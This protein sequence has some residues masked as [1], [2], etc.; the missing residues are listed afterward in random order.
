MFW[1]KRKQA[2]FSAEIEAHLQLEIERLR[3]RGLSAADAETAARL[4]FGNVTR[5]EERFYE[6]GRWLWWER[7]K[8]DVRFGLRMLKRNPAFSVVAVLTLALGIGANTAIFSLIQA[9]LLRPLPFPEPDRLVRIWERRP[10]SREA[11]LPISG[12]EFA[13]WK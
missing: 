12:H 10:S 4:R 11:N 1:R 2:D 5:V 3:E 7:L 8:Q 13:A 9:V 6:S